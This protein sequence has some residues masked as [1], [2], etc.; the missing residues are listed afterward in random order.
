MQDMFRQRLITFCFY[1]CVMQS[2]K[3]PHPIVGYEFKVTHEGK[4]YTIKVASYDEETK[5]LTLDNGRVHD[6]VKD[7]EQFVTSISQLMP[8]MMLPM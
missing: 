6:G 2:V 1:C 7:P 3:K 5:I 4:E 8:A